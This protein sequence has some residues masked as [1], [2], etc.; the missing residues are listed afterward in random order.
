MGKKSN[1]TPRIL[2]DQR[3]DEADEL[4]RIAQEAIEAAAQERQEA[5]DDAEIEAQIALPASVVKANYKR[6]YR[7][8]ARAAGIRSK[9]AKRSAWDWL[10]E[11]LAGEILTEKAKLKVDAFVAILEANGIEAPL[12]RW[13]SQTPGWEGRLRM[14]GRLCLQRIVA[15][16]GVL[17]IPTEDGFEELVPPAEWVAKHLN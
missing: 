16:A 13:P 11:T 15:E 17:L 6:K 8:R 10:A 2:E 7:D 4:A 5:L 14:T 9:A 1:Q 3:V 12:T